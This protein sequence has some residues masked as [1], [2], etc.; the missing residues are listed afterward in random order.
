M[1]QMKKVKPYSVGPVCLVGIVASMTA[2]SANSQ[3]APDEA[4]SLRVFENFAGALTAQDVTEIKL[5]CVYGRNGHLLSA[6]FRRRPLSRGGSQGFA[7]ELSYLTEK[8]HSVR[9]A[10]QDAVQGNVTLAPAKG[11]P[12]AFQ[13]LSPTWNFVLH[14]GK[15]SFYVESSMFSPDEVILE[16]EGD[17]YRM[18]TRSMIS[19]QERESDSPLSEWLD[20]DDGPGRCVLT[21]HASS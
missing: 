9:F 10:S 3:A 4:I 21:I 7:V 15:Q 11:I 12:G 14:Y 18:I 1:M 2:W 8:G 19:Y 16:R 13:K 17:R 20:Y 6:D 5:D